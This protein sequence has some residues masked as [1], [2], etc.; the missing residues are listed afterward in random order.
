[1]KI[2]AGEMGIQVLGAFEDFLYEQDRNVQR[3]VYG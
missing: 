3:L 2:V 1:M